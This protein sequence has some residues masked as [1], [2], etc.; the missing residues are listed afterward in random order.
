MRAFPIG[1]SPFS[2]KELAGNVWEWCS[3]KCGDG[4]IGSSPHFND[5]YNQPVM[6]GEDWRVL[7]GCSWSNDRVRAY[8]ILRSGNLP[9]ARK[10]YIGVRL[11][12]IIS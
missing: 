5:S 9:Y 12:C 7:K 10:P 11:V 2:V 1:V 3:S 6:G 8:S 4:P